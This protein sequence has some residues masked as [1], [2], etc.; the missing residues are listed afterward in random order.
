MAANVISRQPSSPTASRLPSTVQVTTSPTTGLIT[1]TKTLQPQAAVPLRKQVFTGSSLSTPEDVARQLNT[2]QTQVHDATLPSR[3]SSR[4]QAITFEGL[5]FDST[6]TAPRT[7][8]AVTMNHN[9]GTKVRWAV[10]RWY[11]VPASYSVSAITGATLY[12]PSDSQ[13]DTDVLI[14]R[15]IGGTLGI[16]DIE[17]WSAV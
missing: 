17:V 4:A 10:V 6:V 9:L 2:M 5:L 7:T 14:L 13:S 11:E 16:A 15:P 12:E 3:T 1:G 8:S